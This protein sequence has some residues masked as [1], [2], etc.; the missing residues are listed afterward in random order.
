M[1]SGA[2][3]LAQRRAVTTTTKRVKGGL[4]LKA[5]AH[6][7]V[8]CGKQASEYDHRDYDKPEQIEPVCASCNRKRGSAKFI[9]PD[10]PISLKGHSAFVNVAMEPAAKRELERLA[11]EQGWS[12]STLIRWAIKQYIGEQVK[13]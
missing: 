11:K 9:E 5:T 12:I 2:Y 6:K 3:R 7:C 1:T 13:P 8:D 10:K 4:I